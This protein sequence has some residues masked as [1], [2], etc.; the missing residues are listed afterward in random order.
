MSTWLYLRCLDHDPPLI[1]DGE[2]G[3]HL[4]DLPQIRD[5]IA[6]RE[7]IVRYIEDDV[8]P[9]DNRFQMNTYRFL[10]AHP[11]CR[12]DIVDEYNKTHP[13]TE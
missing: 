10:H 9:D 1:A 2:S 5:D 3:Q 13:I 11:K 4:Y 7:D 12:V 8:W 6:N